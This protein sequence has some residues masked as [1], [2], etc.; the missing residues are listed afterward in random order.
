MSPTTLR[1]YISGHNLNGTQV[2][3]TGQRTSEANH[4][5]PLR[6]VNKIGV[7]NLR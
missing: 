1:I 4:L 3:Q 6:Q 5:T 7:V 2:P